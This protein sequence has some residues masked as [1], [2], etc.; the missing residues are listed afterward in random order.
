[1]R[2]RRGGTEKPKEL[3]PGDRLVQGLLR[4]LGFDP[5]SYAIFEIWDRL[6]GRQAERVRATGLQDGRL[7]VEVDSS[8]H[9][10]DITLR[11]RQLLRKLNEH[12]G[13]RTVVS[14][15]IL[16]LKGAPAPRPKG[17]FRR[18]ADRKGAKPPRPWGYGRKETKSP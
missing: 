5:Q 14:D 3:V 10:H 13:T 18:P 15:I 4:R 1:V 16:Q 11:K 9:L 12:F 2:G 7:V 8:A 6:L 17:V